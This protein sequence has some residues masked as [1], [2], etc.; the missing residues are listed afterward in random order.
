MFL[1]ILS[2]CVKLSNLEFIKSFNLVSIFFS[3]SLSSTLFGTT[4]SA[5]F[6]GVAATLSDAMSESV[7]S[8]E[9]PIAVITG[10]LELAIER[11]ISSLLKS[12]KS[13][14]LPPPRPT[15]ITSTSVLFASAIFL[16]MLRV[17]LA[18]CTVVFQT[19]ISAGH[20]FSMLFTM[21]FIAF[22]LADVITPI[23]LGYCGIAFLSLNNPSL[24]NFFLSFSKAMYK[25]PNPASCIFLTLNCRF[26][27]TL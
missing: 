1:E 15:I 24:S 22:P 10:F 17:E 7:L 13:W 19:I 21:S 20:L 14:V 2:L 6:V 5:A 12:H 23:F 18:P 16:V 26:P 25:S 11:T 8:V 4:S 27:R 9:W 3:F